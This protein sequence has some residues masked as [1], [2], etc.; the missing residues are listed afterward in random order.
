M[1]DGGEAYR[2]VHGRCHAR[3]C[4]SARWRAWESIFLLLFEGFGDILLGLPPSGAERVRA[5]RVSSTS[6]VQFTEVLFEKDE[7]KRKG[8]LRHRVSCRWQESYM[9]TFLGIIV[10]YT[11]MEQ[12]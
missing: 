3:L 7:E 9:L 2:L 12:T 6:P 4:D 1:R 10:C 5:D 8:R 11:S